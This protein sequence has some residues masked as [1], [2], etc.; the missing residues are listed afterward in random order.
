MSREGKLDKIL[1]ELVHIRGVMD[2]QDR[3]YSILFDEAGRMRADSLREILDEHCNL[4]EVTE[5]MTKGWVQL[6][7]TGFVIG[8]LSCIDLACLYHGINPFN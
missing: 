1:D 6:I 3:A 4:P 7:F 2:R 5:Q 8:F